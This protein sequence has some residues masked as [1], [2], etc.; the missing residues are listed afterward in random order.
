MEAF[1]EHGRQRLME[2]LM[3]RTPAPQEVAI[4]QEFRQCQVVFD[5]P[6]E[7]RNFRPRDVFYRNISGFEVDCSVA[8]VP[9]K[10]FETKMKYTA[11]SAELP[12]MTV[13][14]PLG[15]ELSGIVCQEDG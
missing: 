9:L 14:G 15:D 3:N 6:L 10:E 8:F 11:V 1:P 2:I 13:L 5:S 4:A 7:S 12:I